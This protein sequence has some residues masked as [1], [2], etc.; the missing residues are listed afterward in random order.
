MLPSLVHK[1]TSLAGTWGAGRVLVTRVHTPSA[2]PH[3]R[4]AS[5]HRGD[6]ESAP[7]TR[8][9]HELRRSVLRRQW[10][11]GGLLART[12]AQV[13]AACT[14]GQSKGMWVCGSLGGDEQLP[15]N[16][17]SRAQGA[18]PGH[19]SPLLKVDSCLSFSQWTVGIKLCPSPS[20]P[21]TEW[22]TLLTPLH[23]IER[24]LAPW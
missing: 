15:R 18:L 3:G 21:L 13:S 17:T 10:R 6:S 9:E 23:L 12:R 4:P 7:L 20:P 8:K 19:F 2:V 24:Q 11:N 14:C 5:Q 1:P 22:V 16:K